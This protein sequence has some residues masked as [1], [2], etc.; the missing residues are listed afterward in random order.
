[1]TIDKNKINASPDAAI[2]WTI[3][4]IGL[5]LRRNSELRWHPDMS[6]LRAQHTL[7]LLEGIIN[8]E[9]TKLYHFLTFKQY[10]VFGYS[11][12][13]TTTLLWNNTPGGKIDVTISFSKDNFSKL[14]DHN[15]IEVFWSYDW[16]NEIDVEK[17]S[18]FSYNQFINKRR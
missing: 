9:F 5:K 16:T 8:R 13:K 15:V 18:Q 2:Q 1:M 17:V 14:D 4:Q 11:V 7:T 10:K 3:T 12:K 6:L